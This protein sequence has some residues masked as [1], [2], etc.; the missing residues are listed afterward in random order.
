MGKRGKNHLTKWD[1]IDK[2]IDKFK[3]EDFSVISTICIKNK[4][5]SKGNI[6]IGNRKM[7][8]TCKICNY[9]MHQPEP[10]TDEYTTINRYERDHNIDWETLGYGDRDNRTYYWLNHY[11]FNHPFELSV[12]TKGEYPQ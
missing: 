1:C 8:R 12:I 3:P 6:V 9:D 7:C 5:V 10:L 11:K 4:C 2:Y